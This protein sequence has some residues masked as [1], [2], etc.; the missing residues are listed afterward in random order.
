MHRLIL[1][2]A[3]IAALG[4]FSPAIAQD[5]TPVDQ[6]APAALNGPAVAASADAAAAAP[7]PGNAAEAHPDAD[8]AIVV[9]GT[10]RPAGDVLGG[11]AVLD[12]EELTH[13][14]KPSLGDTLADLPGVGE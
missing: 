10:R 12:T 13:D 14:L 4:P 11:V 9:T 8:Q 1:S 5:A 2:T 7:V 6:N 3:A